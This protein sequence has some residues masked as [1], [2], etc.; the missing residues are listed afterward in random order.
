MES[1]PTSVCHRFTSLQRVELLRRQYLQML[2]PEKLTLPGKEELILP[3]TQA[4]IFSTMF[5]EENISFVPPARY[6]FRVLKKIIAA[7]EQSI[8][9]PEEDVCLPLPCFFYC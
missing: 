9:D 1:E 2:E 5:N 6:R 4:N 8:V 7:L 3:Q